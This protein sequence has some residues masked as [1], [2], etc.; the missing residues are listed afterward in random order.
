MLSMSSSFRDV[1]SFP[2]SMFHRVSHSTVRRCLKKK[3]RCNFAHRGEYGRM[4]D[5][6]SNTFITHVTTDNI[7]M[8][9]HGSALSIGCTSGLR[10]CWRPRGLNINL[11]GGEFFCILG[12]R[13]QNLKLF[14]WMLVC[15]WTGYHSCLLGCDDRSVTFIEEYRI[16]NPWSSRKLLANSQIQTQTEGKPRC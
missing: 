16:T 14:R 3:K 12:S 4:A 7:V 5:W 11:G 10:F 6:T 1:L 9:E 2:I 13:T 15:E 8:C